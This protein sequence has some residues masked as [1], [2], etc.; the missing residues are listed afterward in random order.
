MLDGLTLDQFAVF[1]TVVEEGSFSAA[2]RRL[3]RAQT[4]ITYIVQGLEAQTGTDLFDRS[5]YRPVLTPAGRA[6]LPR[7]RRI[8]D[9]VADW[10]TQ[11]RSLTQGVEARLT[12]A[13]DVVVP[14]EPL[15]AALRAFSA[16][17]PM[18]EV[19]LLMQPLEATFAALREGQADLGFVVDVPDPNLLEGLERRPCGRLRFIPV[20]APDHPLAQSREPLTPDLLH[21]H[22]QLLLST[23]REGGGA[24][25]YGAHA[26]NR[27]RV[28]DLGLRHRLLLAGVGWS[29]MPQHLVAADLAEGR[30][31]ALTLDKASM[32]ELP[33]E[34]PLSLAHLRTRSPGPAGRWLMARLMQEGA[35]PSDAGAGHSTAQRSG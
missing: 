25:D 8:L 16:T 35:G 13:L 7:A 3:N 34:L 30:L 14:T 29:S 17:F 27:W 9:S 23:G 28:T 12:L 5:G 18:V 22:S 33:P 20:A 2:A 19:S 31:V 4:A 24:R 15:A 11:A 26:V 21:D 1:V 6:L 32:A 10:R